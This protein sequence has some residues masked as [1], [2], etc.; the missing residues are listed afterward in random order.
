MTLDASTKEFAVW[1]LRQD[2]RERLFNCYMTQGEAE[3]VAAALR[4][5]GCRARAARQQDHAGQHGDGR[6]DGR[7][8][9]RADERPSGGGTP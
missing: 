4:R 7:A 5:V 6:A 1:C 2:G 9:Q 3:G 8:D